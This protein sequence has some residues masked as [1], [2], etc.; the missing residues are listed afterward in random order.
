M[1]IFIIFAFFSLF[2]HIYESNHKRLKFASCM[3]VQN[4]FMLH[5]TLTTLFFHLCLVDIHSKVK[6]VFSDSILLIVL[7]L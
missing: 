3:C 6:F 5:W 7:Y 2:Y 4:V 1:N